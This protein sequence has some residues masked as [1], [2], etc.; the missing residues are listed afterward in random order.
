MF[1]PEQIHKLLECLKRIGFPANHKIIRSLHKNKSI[2]LN[3]ADENDFT[4][5]RIAIQKKDNE[6]IKILYSLEPKPKYLSD[7]DRA[8]IDDIVFGNKDTIKCLS[9]PSHRELIYCFQALYSIDPAIVNF[10]MCFGI[11]HMRRQAFFSGET[12]VFRNR[13]KNIKSNIWPIIQRAMREVE[14]EGIAPQKDLQQFFN[15]VRIKLDNRFPYNLWYDLYAF[16][17]GVILSFAPE[18]F[19]NLF[20]SG[21]NL[22]NQEKLFAEPLIRP[23]KLE[24]KGTFFPS[25]HIF[26]GNYTE[27]T[28]PIYFECLDDALKSLDV[29]ISLEIS[30]G[31]HA[32]IIDYAKGKWIFTDANHLDDGEKECNSKEIAQLLLKYYGQPLIFSARSFI[33]SDVEKLVNQSFV[34]LK[35]N[36]RW[37]EL[38][39]K[40][41]KEQTKQKNSAG[42]DLLYV[43]AKSGDVDTVKRCI[44]AGADCNPNGNAGVT[45]FHIAI[46]LGH[47]EIFKELLNVFKDKK[48]INQAIT[49]LGLTPLLIATTKGNIEIVKE[50]L[51]VLKDQQIINQSTK[52]GKTTLYIAVESGFTTVVEELL[53]NGANLEIPISVSTQVLLEAAKKQNCEKKLRQLFDQEKIGDTL[54]GFSPLHAAVFFGHG[55]VVALLQKNG[56][57]FETPKETISIYKL[58]VAMNRTDLLPPDLQQHNKLDSTIKKLAKK[59]EPQ[60]IQYIEIGRASCR[61]RVSS[62]V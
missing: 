8:M 38:H 62:P 31:N 25:N 10:G 61:E 60:K 16:F 21:T 20:E 18:K 59:L 46:Q 48:I 5:L 39:E 41:T 13:L 19:S 15:K 55:D 47:Y 58:A 22:E 50:L 54:P 26:S 33:T 44:N 24:S 56:A 7:Y 45:P 17:D 3:S 9:A 12:D 53:K 51:N 23:V 4:P 42:Y 30:I 49:T 1:N 36:I 57:K 28:L 14:N 34:D 6:A 43:A 27:L 52:S 37:I 32:F 2:D 11:S 40:I 29:P 35:K